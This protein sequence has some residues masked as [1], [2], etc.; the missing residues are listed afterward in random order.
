MNLERKEVA[1]YTRWISAAATTRE[2]EKADAFVRGMEIIQQDGNLMEA[3]RAHYIR[4]GA[5]L[6]LEFLRTQV[7]LDEFDQM[8]AP[9]QDFNYDA[10]KILDDELMRN[11]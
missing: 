7:K 5:E 11:Q 2:L 8:N 9:E 4:K 3:A 6:V 10:Q 1:A